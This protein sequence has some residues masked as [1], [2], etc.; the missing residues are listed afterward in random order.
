MLP[1]PAAQYL[2]PVLSTYS[3]SMIR[4]LPGFWLGLLLW[5]GCAQWTP[6]TAQYAPLNISA[7]TLFLQ[8]DGS[9][10]AWGDN[11][12][13]QLGDG[14][15]R[16]RPA[17]TVIL[18]GTTWKSVST[19]PRHSAAIRQDGTLWLWGSNEYGQLGN[20]TLVAQSVPT[21]S[22]PGSR[23]H[24]VAAAAAATVAVR[25]DGTLWVWGERQPTP[26]QFGTLNTWQTV[27]AGDGHYLALQQNGTLWAWGSN[28]S[29]QLGH[30]TL[31][32]SAVP[33][34]VKPGSLWKSIDAEGN[35]SIG[36]Q[37]NGSLWHWGSFAP[38]GY[39]STANPYEIQPNKKWLQASAGAFHVAAVQDNGALWTWGN[40]ESGQLGNGTTFM[41]RLYD[42]YIWD[43]SYQVHPGSTWQSAVA[44]GLHTLAV[45]HDGSLWSWGT[46][47]AGQTG[48]AALFPVALNA[49]GQVLNATWRS[50][51]TSSTHT[52]AVRQ[53][54]TLWTW[55][56]NQRGQLGDGTTTSRS[57]PVQLGN[58]TSWLSASAGPS[59]TVAIRQDGTLWSWGSNEFGQLGNGTTKDYHRPRQIDSL[60]QWRRWWSVSAGPGHVVALEEKGRLWSW[61]NNDQGQLGTGD[62]IHRLLPVYL[63]NGILQVSPGQGYTVALAEDGTLLG[64][65]LNSSGQLGN[66]STTS[67]LTF[68][69]I[70]LPQ[71][72]PS[73][74]K[75][76]KAGNQ[77]TVGIS[78][79]G[80]LWAWGNN[81]T[82]QL[83]TGTTA[84]SLIPA[85]IGTATT[86]QTL[87]AGPTHSA[88][89]QQ[90]GS[91]WA[92]G[93]NTNGQLGMGNTDPLLQPTRV[94]GAGRWQTLTTNASSGG[95]QQNGSLWTWGSNAYGQLGNGS[96]TSQLAPRAI[97]QPTWQQVS[98]GYSFSAGLQSDGS[99]WTWGS[100]DNGQL[101]NRTTIGHSSPTQ[102]APGSKWKT[103]GCGWDHIAAIRQDGTLWGWGL[104]YID[105]NH[106]PRV[107][108]AL[109]SADTTWRSVSTGYRYTMA[110]RRDGS[111]WGWGYNSFN[112]NVLPGA[113]WALFSPVPVMP[114]SKWKSV[115]AGHEHTAAIREDGTLWTWGE[116]QHGLL[117]NGVLDLSKYG[118]V[119]VAPGSKWKSVSAG[120]VHTTAIREDG[121]LWAW[122]S[123]YF[124]LLG[125]GAQKYSI[126]PVQIA[127]GTT[128]QSVVTGRGYTLAVRQDGT[129][130]GWGLNGIHQLGDGSTTDR[131]A[132]VQL[133]SPTNWV[134]YAAGGS[135]ALV[136]R[137]DGTLWAWGNNQV[138]Q[139]GQSPLGT[140]PLML[141]LG[142][143][144]LTAT[145]SAVTAAP[146]LEAPLTAWPVPF[147][148]TGVQVQLRPLQRGPAIISLLNATGRV[149][150]QQ[151]L[152]ISAATTLAIPQTGPLPSGLYL[153]RLQQGTQQ[154][155]LRI[156]HE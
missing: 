152:Y 72:T 43:N 156:V 148:S 14:T 1:H 41:V 32:S 100:N 125:T 4:L 99:L 128:W 56:N 29:R 18:P 109:V 122:G 149:L 63:S 91:L 86:W 2:S 134:S 84:N 9:L 68:N 115:S 95:I 19:G 25:Q 37:Q 21:E 132:P 129:S 126:V 24:S 36:I 67:L 12:Y 146:A 5:L 108:P 112:G 98:A 97:A 118:P 10:W 28:S 101:G 106:Q 45:R 59:Y 85:R 116:N 138:G 120:T 31:A 137:A 49:A 151:T 150:W 13:G 88:A 113:D 74:W 96:T 153:L 6:A 110:I 55:G 94:P 123:V 104:A 87:A 143:Q 30:E 105:F 83:G 71:G 117:G 26:Q 57:V 135:H 60:T 114:G 102:V 89:L 54:G 124:D 136:I 69:R 64:C 154:A 50:V 121:T 107:V 44:T 62:K 80:S 3:I 147:G 76:V 133:P 35:H 15:T 47:S 90:D 11:R 66:N 79:D 33:I 127:P 40:N 46:N 130:W 61:G 16:N 17:P 65:G 51:S 92:W 144:V 139:L 75:E 141:T 39:P 78:K 53:D 93:D 20:G 27:S 48:S 34:Q 77:H 111:L 119:Q 131:S 82:G 155:V 145:P 22:M 58:L 103:M 70:N 140:V 73:I 142:N 81:A 52:V 8:P 7:H 42:N 38:G 23:W